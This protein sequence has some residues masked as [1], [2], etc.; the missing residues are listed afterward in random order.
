MPV[1]STATA[2]TG[3]MQEPSASLVIG[4]FVSKTASLHTGDA[5]TVLMT[6]KHYERKAEALLLSAPTQCCVPQLLRGHL[7]ALHLL[8]H[9]R[10]AVPALRSLQ[11]VAPRSLKAAQPDS[12][13]GMGT[14]AFCN[15]RGRK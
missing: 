10:T 9:S 5:Q 12:A 4:K 14:A 8:L 11:C 3:A 1:A 13:L 7:M 15:F 6:D 2:C